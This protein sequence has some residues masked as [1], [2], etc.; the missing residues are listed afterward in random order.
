MWSIV[1][2]CGVS[3][4]YRLDSL[5]NKSCA[6]KSGENQLY[7]QRSGGGYVRT[8]LVNPSS[9]TSTSFLRPSRSL[10][11]RL[12]REKPPWA[13]KEKVAMVFLD[14]ATKE[15]P[16]KISKRSSMTEIR[17]DC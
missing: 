13:G 6:G 4:T 16:L 3:I 1:R 11:F 10:A 2:D 15:D 5:H 7:I 12:V 8:Q 9:G 17:R 14:E